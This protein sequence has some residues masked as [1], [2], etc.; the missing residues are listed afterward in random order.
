[1]VAA[2]ISGKNN[3]GVDIEKMS[4]RIE[5]V[6]SKIL[7]EKELETCLSLPV[8]DQAEFK[9]VVWGAKESMFKLYGIGNLDF[10]ENMSITS[11]VRSDRSF[12][13]VIKKG[14][15]REVISG[16]FMPVEEYMLVYV[17]GI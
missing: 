5:K 11:F 10:K 17:L 15:Y 7:N 16:N 4:D 6:A 3:V 1:M 14:D 13:G 8:R 9:Q 2:I 12:T